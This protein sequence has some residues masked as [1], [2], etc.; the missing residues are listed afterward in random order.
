MKSNLLGPILPLLRGCALTCALAASAHAA[1]FVDY[2]LGVDQ[3][4][5]IWT[6]L[7]N[8]N[9]SRTA[10]AGSDPGSFTIG[11]PGY[12]ASVGTYSFSTDYSVTVNQTST[13]DLQT[14]VF[15]VDIAMNPSYTLPYGTGPLLSYNGGSQNLAASLFTTNGTELRNTSFG[16]MNYVGG[17]WQWD[18]SGITE[19]ISSIT[20]TMPVSVHSSIS[21]ARID[22][23]SSNLAVVPEPSMMGL[24]LLG[25]GLLV[26]RRR[27][28][29]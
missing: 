4:T 15:Q 5:T 21:A 27:R 17:A 14:A 12:Q 16:P 10:D 19:N 11:A 7:N 26:A 20:I 24:A 22:S 1:L 13:F 6:T 25:G 28:A 29:V 18:L 3:N 23:G 8:T 2:N 9:P